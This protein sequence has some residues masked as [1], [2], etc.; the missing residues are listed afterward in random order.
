M[1][2]SDEVNKFFKQNDINITGVFHVGAHECEE[3]SL[4]KKF[5]IEPKNIIWVDALPDKVKEAKKKGIL[6]IYNAVVAD[7]DDEEVVFNVAN[8]G[9]SSSLLELKTHLFEHPTV[10]FISS[11]KAKTITI[12]SFFERNNI[13]IEDARRHNLWNF[14]IQG[15]EL[16]ALKGATNFLPY[17]KAI[18]ME[19]NTEE[20]Y[21]DGALITEIDNFLKLFGFER[22]MTN[23]TRNGW[24][25]ALYIIKKDSKKD[26]TNSNTKIKIKTK[27][28]TKTRNKTQNQLTR[29]TQKSIKYLN[30][31]SKKLKNK[32]IYIKNDEGFGH[33]VLDMIFALYL[34]NLYEGKCDV[35]YIL[36]RS[37][38]ETERDPTLNKIFPRVNKK[39]NF[40]TERQYENININPLI[41]IYKI[42]NNDNAMKKLENF[43]KY[44]E[45]HHYTKFDN[46]LT[47]VYQMYKTFLNEDK[48]IFTNINPIYIKYNDSKLKTS[49]KLMELF[50]N[51]KLEYAVVHIRYGN[52]LY[53]LR[54]DIKTSR[55]NYYLLYTPQY[56]ID[57]IYML[58][59]K[60][61]KIVIVTDSEVVVRNFILNKPI[62]NKNK[63]IILLNT[64]WINSF[65]LLCHA[66]YIVMSYSALS[67]SASY[68]NEN[69]IC[70]LV[71]Q[72][73]K[74]RN[75]ISEHYEIS[76]NCIVNKEKKYI[77]N[78]NKNLV[79]KMK[80]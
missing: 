78:Y 76:P 6:N 77:L 66:K 22:V 65:Y 56:Y 74:D 67:I 27:T 19:V 54:K 10:Q 12:N 13:D 16:M 55:F 47:I 73:A 42:N 11:F 30:S 50:N 44:S 51:K 17:V 28:K 58:L 63:N 43:P 49:Q 60:N 4:Y 33:K 37:I 32:Q 62:F 53:Y 5:N 35:N 9:Q 41:K 46:N 80:A 26:K 8:N 75:E 52:K 59:K 39:I 21:K 68:I 38:Y 2:N 72:D 45:L 61:I 48:A 25:D 69:A 20:L 18:I 34:Y 70:Y 31:L 57:M 15:A 23:M 71:N 24:G 3:I 1:L 14:D 29:K 7:K 40:I 79:Y 36:I 64:H